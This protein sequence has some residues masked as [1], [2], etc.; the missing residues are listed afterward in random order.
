MESVE[1]ASVPRT[2]KQRLLV[3][4]DSPVQAAHI[5]EILEQ[6]GFEVHVAASVAQALDLLAAG[7][8][9]L[10]LTDLNM[11]GE[12]GLD[13]CRHIR[14]SKNWT[15]TPVI[16]LTSDEDPDN[17]LKGLEAGAWDFMTKGRAPSEIARRVRKVLAT[18]QQALDSED[19]G[20]IDVSFLGNAYQIE[21]KRRELLGVLLSALE[22]MIGFN[23]RLRTLGDELQMQRDNLRAT[24]LGVL[25]SVP[26]GLVI[27]EANGISTMA[28]L[29][30]RRLLGGDHPVPLSEW[31]TRY[32]FRRVDGEPLSIDELPTRLTLLDGIDRR[33]VEVCLGA[34][35][36]H[37]LFFLMN[38]GAIRGPNKEVSA[39]CS[40]FIDITGIKR[41][42]EQERHLQ[43]ELARASRLAAVG[44]LAGG[45]AHEVNNPLMIISGMSELLMASGL[46]EE[47]Q[48][49]LK[50]V[51]KASQRC[52]SIVKKLLAFS[53]ED[54]GTTAQF[55]V[56][57]QVEE[58]CRFLE[59]QLAVK[60]IT[61]VTH[62]AEG[63]P[64]VLGNAGELLQIL[65]N[66]IVN[67]QDAMP[68]GGS[69]TIT[70]RM[71]AGF[72]DLLVSDTGCG[73]DPSVIHRIFDPFFTTKDVGQG[74]GLGLSLVQTMVRNMRGQL[75]VESTPGKGTAFAISFPANL[76]KTSPQPSDPRRPLPVPRPL[77]VLV[78]DDEPQIRELCKKLLRRD[79]HVCVEAQD[80]VEA[81]NRLRSSRFD[82]VLIDVAMPR[83][84]GLEVVRFIQRENLR[85]PI[86]MMTGK[87]E[88]DE[89]KEIEDLGVVGTLNKPFSLVQLR[90]IIARL[91]PP[92]FRVLVIEE[93]SMLR[94]ILHEFLE[95]LELPLT[96]DDA[97]DGIETAQK[98]GSRAPDAVVLDLFLNG[99]NGLDVCRTVRRP[100]FDPSPRIVV[101]LEPSGGV[102]VQSARDAGADEVL[103]KPVD[104][105]C[106]TRLG[107]WLEQSV[108]LRP[109]H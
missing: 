104:K 44:Q 14:S 39:V 106:L 85:V 77:D 84:N 37:S 88:P 53:R 73:I 13:L 101:L 87:I 27:T 32:E 79:G 86:I 4:D 52:G 8:I 63:L 15:S 75:R 36:D 91:G 17:I 43:D 95:K 38:T 47:Q 64:P 29:A 96:V 100:C 11:P 28:N 97:C 93:N 48:A 21:S 5:T 62:L 46:G 56:N 9:D 74:T 99:V 35:P 34:A 26:V 102:D 66:L 16:V 57:D 25:D 78:V 71:A 82:L 92:R 80:G 51:H 1:I 33:D 2:L 55:S 41:A 12:N 42:Q 50:S 89:L 30:A 70:T 108:R 18:R 59:R 81:T 40:S 103:F 76:T 10:V 107:D 72:V 7:P 49:L 20:P 31:P 98:L 23:S 65:T 67:A 69:L 58:V 83:M 45:V 90:E 24:L 60:N 19:H 3:V 22:D 61:V 6:E 105:E 68:F 54:G 109:Q 94:Q